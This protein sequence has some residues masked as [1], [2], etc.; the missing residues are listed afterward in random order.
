MRFLLS[1]SIAVASLI[2]FDVYAQTC[3]KAPDCATLGYTKTASQCSGRTYV[4]CPFDT[5]KYSCDTTT[6]AD[7]GY[8][9]TIAECPGEYEV[10][11]YD[12]TKGNCIYEARPGDLKYSLKTT[13]HNGWLLCDG[14]SYGGFGQYPELY[15]AISGSYGI[16]L[17]NFNNYFIKG[18]AT[19][20]ASNLKPEIG[21][22]KEAAGLPNIEGHIYSFLT[23]GANTNE[24]ALSQVSGGESGG[25]NG[26]KYTWRHIYFDASKS[27]SIYGNSTTVTPQNY[28]ANVFIF[29]GK[30]KDFRPSGKFYLNDGNLSDTCISSSSLG[31]AL[32]DSQYIFKGG[33]GLPGSSPFVGTVFLYNAAY[34][35]CKNEGGSLASASKIA[36]YYGKPG[37]GSSPVAVSSSREYITS[38]T[39]IYKITGSNSYSEQTISADKTY[40]YYC[41]DSTGR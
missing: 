38:D 18:A 20:S 9:D 16:K 3:Q 32:T 34:T 19:T 25:A 31:Y 28:K 39:K 35:S 30:K 8:T 6:C 24:G 2:S 23:G 14:N 26:S 37:C 29:A 17:P 10:C 41:V 12:K 11:Q 4:V 27:N 15:S 1:A 7:L 36:S 40:Y 21:Y 13:D 5:N 22:G 33:D